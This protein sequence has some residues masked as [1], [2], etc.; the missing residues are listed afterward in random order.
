MKN[1][2]LRGSLFGLLVRSYLLFTLTLLLIASALFWL[3]NSRL[4]QIYQPPDWD[5]L[6]KDPALSAGAYQE[7]TRY[8]KHGRGDFAIYDGDGAQVYASGGGFDK[9]YTAEELACILP[10]GEPVAVDVYHTTQPD[11]SHRHLLV[12]TV[13]QDGTQSPT[14]EIMVLDENLQVAFGGFG[15]GRS[16]YTQREF[17]LLSSNELF[18][19]PFQTS[20]GRPMTAVLRVTLLSDAAYQTAYQESWRIWLLFLPLYLGV[21]AL[22]IFQLRRTIARP[23]RR[24]NDAVVAQ[25]ENRPVQPG[26]WSGPREIRR[27]GESLDRFSQQLA[28]SEAQRRQMDQDRQKLIAD[29]S[30]DLK[31]PI[32]VIAGYIDAICDGK[33]PPEEQER[34]LR[35]IHGKAEALT[36]LVN[37]FHE[38][39]KVEH[40]EFVLRP[41]RTDLCEFLRE[42]LADKYDEI[43]LASFSLEVSIPDRPVFCLLDPMQFRRVLDNLLSNALRHN[44]LGTA[45]FF[46]IS[47]GPK[48]ALLRMGD[49]GAGIPPERAKRIFD[50]FVVGSEAR[51]GKGSGLGLS[52][53]R[54]IMEKHGGAI[55]LNPHPTPGRSTEFLLELPLASPPSEKDSEP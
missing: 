11:G 19:A 3:W 14:P 6:L 7:L 16:G 18:R 20:D 36:E 37:A 50:P 47:A 51:S 42:Y 44:R 48:T 1:K 15:D 41:E 29:I 35:A 2:R 54:R 34:Y 21:T 33:V 53:T 46:D 26:S 12:R 43:D 31:T 25:S 17:Q 23:L 38:Y 39:S 28:E 30:H 55:T 13:Y 27:I 9:A 24:L 8:L 5:G 49:N 52:I 10:Y 32:T 4:D 40:P 45:L 22:F